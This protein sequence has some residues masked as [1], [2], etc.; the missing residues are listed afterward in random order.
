MPGGFQYARRADAAAKDARA[1]RVAGLRVKDAENVFG[2]LA[3][4]RELAF[5][6]QVAFLDDQ[7]VHAESVF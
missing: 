1:D 2:V 7:Q 4:D 3:A 5:G 6:R